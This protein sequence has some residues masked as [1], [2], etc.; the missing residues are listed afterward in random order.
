MPGF[1]Q[2]AADVERFAREGGRMLMQYFRSDMQV[3]DKGVSNNLVSEA[4]VAT[5][6]RIVALIQAGYPDDHVLAEEGSGGA[7]ASDGMW[8]IDPLD[9]TNNFANGLGQFATSVAYY[10][11]GVAQCGAIY[12]PIRDEMYTATRGGG[13]FRNGQCLRVSGAT[14]LPQCLVA[15][16]FYY[17]RNE[18]MRHTLRVVEALFGQNIQ[19]MR[20]CGAATLDLCGVATGTYGAYFEFVLS[21]W[22]FAAGRL[23][24]EE[25]GGRI[26]DCSGAA[27][28]V[29]RTSMLA[30][31]GL[32]HDEMLRLIEAS[33]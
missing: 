17:E 4:D 1:Q 3:R 11:A 12:D 5:E 24:V 26:S 20:R 13:S 2:I 10:H 33:A 31:N 19:G 18:K 22:D 21:P 29:D 30:S 8:I 32:L 16:G 27:I 9:G 6:E 23:I 25:A 15:T 7:G 28:P 14:A